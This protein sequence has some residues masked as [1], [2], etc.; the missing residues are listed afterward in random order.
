MRNAIKLYGVFDT[1]R[2]DPRSITF[3]LS[4]IDYIIHDEKTRN[5]VVC[6]TNGSMFFAPI[7]PDSGIDSVDI[8]KLRSVNEGELSSL[9]ED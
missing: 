9:I 7:F 1:A 4:A 8:V 2:S 5:A 3:P 6:C